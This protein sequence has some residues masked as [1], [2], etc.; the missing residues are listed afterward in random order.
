MDNNLPLGQASKNILIVLNSILLVWD[1]AFVIS[2]ILTLIE[3]VQRRN[4]AFTDLITPED[5]IGFLV[6]LCVIALYIVTIVFLVKNSLTKFKTG[7]INISNISISTLSTLVMVA[8]TTNN[9]MNILPRLMLVQLVR[10]AITIVCLVFVFMGKRRW[11]GVHTVFYAIIA[12]DIFSNLMAMTTGVDR[13]TT[14]NFLSYVFKA[15]F[16]GLI[17]YEA[18]LVL[19]KSKTSKS[20]CQGQ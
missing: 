17:V 6:K 19:I 9:D 5:A 2:Y 3:D 16:D 12:I 4:I 14:L 13:M 8:I 15:I 7:I 1:V 18:V 10:L 11:L 20:Q